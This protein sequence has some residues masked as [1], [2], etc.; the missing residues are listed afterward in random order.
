M[1]EIN[2]TRLRKISRRAN[3]PLRVIDDMIRYPASLS[4]QKAAVDC[5]RQPKRLAYAGRGDTFR[6]GCYQPEKT[7]PKGGV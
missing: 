7:L 1:A 4:L 2:D 5:I 3:P 6:A